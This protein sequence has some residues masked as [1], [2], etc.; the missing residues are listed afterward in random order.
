MIQS[1]TCLILALVLS[2]VAGV[3]SAHAQEDY[4]YW[5]GAISA[6]ESEGSTIFRRALE[7]SV[8]DTLVRGADLAPDQSPYDDP[9]YFYSV[10]LDTIAATIYW[11]DSGGEI[12]PDTFSIGAVRRASHDGDNVEI[13]LDGIVCGVGGL[14][15]LEI[16]AIERTLYFGESNDCPDFGLVKASL[17][18]SSDPHVL[19]MGGDYYVRSIALDVVNDVI[20]WSHNDYSADGLPVGIWRASLADREPEFLV[21][22]DACDIALAHTLSKLYWTPCGGNSIRR[23]NLDGTD[24]EDVIVS[25]GDPAKLA[26][27]HK[28]RQIYWTETAAGKIS[29]ANLDGT[30]VE[31]LVTGL[32]EPASL[33]LNF[34][35]D[36]SVGVESETTAPEGVELKDVYPNPVR[37]SATIAF[38]LR[39]PSHLTLE[40]YD[41]LGRRIETL[42]SRTYPPGAFQLQWNP[43]GRADGLYFLRVA[44]ASASQTLPVVVQR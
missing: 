26:I 12:A 43:T 21:A 7:S 25:E 2:S 28:G 41:V 4:I 31:D 8:T 11:T 35:W 32:I 20:Y 18:G 3:H 34:G 37:T 30:D 36:S 6:D 27:D 40:I 24:A 23:S 15:D 5:I 19:A 42:A 33:A 44:S 16:D 29:R 1:P 22:E 13:F 10:A 38:A 14:T 17:E 9:Q 39:E